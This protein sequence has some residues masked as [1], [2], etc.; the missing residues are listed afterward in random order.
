[1][2]QKL[3]N[4]IVFSKRVKN[5][6]SMPNQPVVGGVRMDYEGVKLLVVR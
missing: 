3:Y 6:E 2:P 4:I 1:M 5:I